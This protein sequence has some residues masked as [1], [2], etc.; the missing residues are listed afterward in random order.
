AVIEEMKKLAPN[1]PVKYVVNS[2]HHL[3]HA[4]GLRTFVAEGATII[5]GGDA[6]KAYYQ[7]LFKLPFTIE[8][9]RLAKNP[10]PANIIAVKDKY[11]LTDGTRSM[12]FYIMHDNTH[13]PGLLMAYLPK[14][15]IALI[16]DSVGGVAAAAPRPGAPP[17]VSVN[18]F[19]LGDNARDNI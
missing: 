19:G 5:T 1:K 10:R 7:R 11:V 14:E 9:D 17:P 13:E 16:A 2:H 3:D 18:N 4:G 12:E 8:P 6:N 15:K